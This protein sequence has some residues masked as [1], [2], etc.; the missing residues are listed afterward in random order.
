MVS[1]T[2]A[3]GGLC[4]RSVAGEYQARKQISG[5]RWGRQISACAA[6]KGSL[7][8]H[9]VFTES[10]T[11]KLRIPLYTS[12]DEPKS[13]PYRISTLTSSKHLWNFRQMNATR[14]HGKADRG[15]RNFA[16]YRLKPCC[17]DDGPVN[18]MLLECVFFVLITLVDVSK[19]KYL[20]QQTGVG[21]YKC[22]SINGSDAHCGDPF[23]PAFNMQRYFAKCEQAQDKRV[24]LFPA[25]YCTKIKGTNLRTNEEMIIRSCSNSAFD[26]TCGLFEFKNTRY[27]GC[28]MSCS[29]DACNG[30]PSPFEPLH[31][32][33][34]SLLPTLLAFVI[35][36]TVGVHRNL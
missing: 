31:Q 18:I 22:H 19:E 32:L 7:T 23:H 24:G 14:I 6:V 9:V 3:W 10:W 34:V 5:T 29:R 4:Y 35:Q 2:C 25:R 16:P 21:C 26:N 30:T 28:L 11:G 33:G 12:K 20:K 1:Q 36:S 8:A 27:S 17:P 15:V 13:S